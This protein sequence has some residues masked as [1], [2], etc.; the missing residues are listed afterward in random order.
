VTGVRTL[1][2][3]IPLLVATILPMHAMH[4][5][6]HSGAV[7][8]TFPISWRGQPSV[9]PRISGQTVI[10]AQPVMRP[11]PMP[12]YS[13]WL[14]SLAAHRRVRIVTRSAVIDFTSQL[15]ISGR[16][17][18]WVDCRHCRRMNGMPGYDNTRIYAQYLA[19]HHTFQ[20]SSLPGTQE[21]P[22]ISGQVITW[23]QVTGKGHTA[24]YARELR[25]PRSIVIAGGS[26]RKSTPSISG[27]IIVWNE[28]INSGWDILGMNLATHTHFV[29]ARH[30]GPGNDLLSP[31]IS[32]HT[33]IWTSR[34]YRR[35]TD[36]IEG[37][38]LRTGRSMVVA[39]LPPNSSNQ[40]T[41]PAAT[42][43]GSIVVWQ[44]RRAVSARADIPWAIY[45]RDLPAGRTF[46]VA[47]NDADNTAPDVSGSVIVWQST[48]RSG[49]QH[50][51]VIYG[52]RV[53]RP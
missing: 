42:I 32:G 26:K 47:A 15:A 49:L 33:V 51:S 5:S 34:W 46:V 31:A 2:Y 39:T 4:A 52:A 50:T 24:I 11:P 44:Q 19:T 21:A 6:R 40:G 29:V 28:F 9:T 13:V 36:I 8:G 22:A 48:K 30:H 43:S 25:S 35:Q 1:R 20:V 23:V 27:H 14:Q 10:W 41:G 7:G 45:A 16:T 37:K 12:A 18:A 17:V 38:N 53:K 3:M